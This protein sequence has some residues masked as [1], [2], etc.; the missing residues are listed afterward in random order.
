MLVSLMGPGGGSISGSH[1]RTPA[2]LE[3]PLHLGVVDVGQDLELLNVVPQA[4]DPCLLGGLA[5]LELASIPRL[6]QLDLLRLLDNLGNLGRA[7]LLQDL[8][9]LLEALVRQ[10]LE[11]EVTGRS[12]GGPSPSRSKLWSSNYC[13][14]YSRRLG[15]GGR[16]RRGWWCCGGG[17]GRRGGGGGGAFIFA[18]RGRGK[19]PNGGD[20]DG[21]GRTCRS[22]GAGLPETAD[23]WPRDLLTRRHGGWEYVCIRRKCGIA[24]SREELH[25]RSGSVDGEDG[26][27][28]GTGTEG[29]WSFNCCSPLG[30]GPDTD[31]NCG[32]NFVDPGPAAQCVNWKYF[33][34]GVAV[35]WCSPRKSSPGTGTKALQRTVRARCTPDLFSPDSPRRP[36]RCDLTGRTGARDKPSYIPLE[37]RLGP[38]PLSLPLVPKRA[39]RFRST[40]QSVLHRPV[41]ALVSLS[42]ISFP[43][44]NNCPEH[45]HADLHHSRSPPA[46]RVALTCNSRRLAI[47]Q[48]SPWPA[49]VSRA[50]MRP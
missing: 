10:L 8:A 21:P 1:V 6:E 37:P 4:L 15:F 31:S 9:R 33:V 2:I 34:V 23:E 20:G 46:T 14:C 48:Q 41:V 3:A 36:N 42:L 16:R 39:P 5:A 38:V 19:G 50:S 22:A 40:A 45:H 17:I 18:H 11:G 12:Q 35:S 44:A 13:V 47:S 43:S 25:S 26:V 29:S 49:R 30:L 24:L 7:V 28:D 27:E 32:Q